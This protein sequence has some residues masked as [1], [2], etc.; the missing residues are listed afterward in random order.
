LKVG[1]VF[2]ELEEDADF[3]ISFQDEPTAWIE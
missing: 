2:N 1:E 3:L